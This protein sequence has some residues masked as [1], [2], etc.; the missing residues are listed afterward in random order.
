M[1]NVLSVNYGYFEVNENNLI[2]NKAITLEFII[3][4]EF[5]YGLYK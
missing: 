3:N 1:P 4:F 5:F 2:K